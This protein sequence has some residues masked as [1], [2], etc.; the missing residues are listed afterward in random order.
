M[1]FYNTYNQLPI[2]ASVGFPI[3]CCHK[4]GCSEQSLHVIMSKM[5]E[6]HVLLSLCDISLAGPFRIGISTISSHTKCLQDAKFQKA[7]LRYSDSEVCG[8]ILA[9][10]IA[11]FSTY[12]LFVFFSFFERFV[13]DPL[14]AVV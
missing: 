5:C 2:F 14:Q 7:G 3:F 11:K 10:L 13:A 12:R 8:I 9:L 4:Q 6:S 1:D